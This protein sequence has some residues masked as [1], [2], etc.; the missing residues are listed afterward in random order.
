MRNSELIIIVFVRTS[1]IKSVRKIGF[2]SS[3]VLPARLLNPI[4]CGGGLRP[5]P[6]RRTANSIKTTKWIMLKLIILNKFWYICS[7][8]I[9]F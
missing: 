5:Y 6:L 3:K 2:S 9:F 4:P 8:Q 1:I 7:F